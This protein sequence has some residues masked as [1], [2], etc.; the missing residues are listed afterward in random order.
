MFEAVIN[1][2]VA[3]LGIKTHDEMLVGLSI[4]PADTKDIQPNTPLTKLVAEQLQA[5][6]DKKLKVFSLP[7]CGMGTSFQKQ[8]WD[9]LY[10]MN[11]GTTK[12]YAE[13]AGELNTGSRAIGNACRRNP[14]VIIVPCHRI[15][16]KKDIGGYSG[17]KATPW[18]DIK[19]WLLY[20][21]QFLQ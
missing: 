20:H 10:A 19:S 7:L 16:A 6:F 18:L 5:Y 2:K 4:V 8:V 14:I 1:S 17:S 11:Y 9:A 15:V 21:E 12:T 3:K 13:L